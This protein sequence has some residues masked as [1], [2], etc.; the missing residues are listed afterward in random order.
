MNKT[1]ATATAANGKVYF[2]MIPTR[3][4]IA[5]HHYFL[6]CTTIFGSIPDIRMINN[7]G[8]LDLIQEYET[9]N[10]RKNHDPDISLP[11]FKGDNW[12]NFGDKFKSLLSMTFG[13]RV[14]ALSYVIHFDDD[15]ATNSK[16]LNE[17]EAPDLTD[18]THVKQN[19]TLFGQKFKEDNEQVY[20]MLSSK[21]QGTVGWNY[22]HTLKTPK[23]GR[24]AFM[25]LKSH[26]EGESFKDV[27]CEKP[28]RL[29]VVPSIMVK[30]WAACLSG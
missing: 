14:I 28:S 1:F 22:I 24:S 6:R 18:S 15:N 11:T 21:L 26:Y 17:V 30:D 16:P 20:N 13:S 25:K 9:F 8:V 10:S 7:D 23:D 27:Y 3:K 5:V 29:L 2:A 12:I 19:A 4:L